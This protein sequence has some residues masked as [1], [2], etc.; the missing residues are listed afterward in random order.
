MVRVSAS[1]QETCENTRFVNISERDDRCDMP[2]SAWRP[3]TENG[4]LQQWKGVLLEKDPM[5][6]AA[7]PMLLHELRP[8]TI[9]ELGALKGGSAL[10]LADQLEQFG[11]AGQVICI[12]HD[13]SQ[14]H[15]VAKTDSR[16]RFLEGN[17]RDIETVLP[18]ALLATLPHPWL[19][20]EDV[21]DNLLGILE[22][23][24]HQGLQAG[25]Y[26]I[27]EDTNQFLWEVWDDWDDQELIQRGSRRMAELRGWLMQHPD[28]YGID[29]Y[30][31]DMYGYNVSKNWNS[32]LKKLV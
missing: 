22:H 18:A 31:Q 23:F 14:L 13:L 26:L 5:Q 7:Y 8:K 16:I 2:K 24:H 17:C 21:H 3:L 20:I 10:W 28:V 30:Y 15:E 12:D 1:E 4:Y 29:T 11:I 25:D 27:I 32:I 9:I 6:I 19:V